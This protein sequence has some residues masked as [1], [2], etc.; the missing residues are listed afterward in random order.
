VRA[1]LLLGALAGSL[2][3]SAPTWLDLV[4]PVITPAEKKTW[5]ALSPVERA[6]FE[7][8]FWADK[9]ISAQEYFRRVAYADATW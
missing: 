9:S 6:K 7:E 1:L 3:A 5:L 4:Q 8:S 2:C